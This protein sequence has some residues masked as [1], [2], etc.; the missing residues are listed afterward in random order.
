MSTESR[1]VVTLTSISL[2]YNKQAYDIFK[3]KLKKG[4]L[5]RGLPHR[6]HMAWR[7]ERVARHAAKQ[8]PLL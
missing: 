7:P 5:K 3:G 6:K 8:V 4:K 2:G 1:I